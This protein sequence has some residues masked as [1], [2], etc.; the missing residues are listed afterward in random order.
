MIVDP[1]IFYRHVDYLLS[2]M[3]RLN[4]KTKIKN[5]ST[6]I[7]IKFVELTSC[8]NF[9]NSF[10]FV[11]AGTNCNGFSMRTAFECVGEPSATHY[12]FTLRIPNIDFAAEQFR[13]RMQFSFNP[14]GTCEFLLK[15]FVKKIIPCEWGQHA[16]ESP[17]I[18]PSHRDTNQHKFI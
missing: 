15:R 8:C 10:G 6:T 1:L 3:K 18:K 16:A 11:P 13:D 7:R 4:L 17:R 9:L 5:F 14:D 12:C 2:W